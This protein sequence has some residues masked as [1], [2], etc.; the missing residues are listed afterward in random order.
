M[1]EKKYEVGGKSARILL[2]ALSLLTLVDFADRSVLTISLQAIKQAFDLTD[3]QAGMLP[4]LLQLGIALL[5]LPVSIFGDRWARRKAV[6]IMTTIWSIFTV[7]TGLAT[8]FW[9]M[10]VAR[11]MVGAGEAG[12]MPIGQTWMSV[13]FRKDVRSLMFSIF[14]MFM[15]IGTAI[16]TILGGIILTAT[17]NWR[18]AFFVFG[19]PG[20]LVA[21]WILFMRDYTVVKSGEGV[22]TKEYFKSWSKILRI[23]SWWLVT[24]TWLF[25]FFYNFA[26]LA[27]IPTLAIR[28]YNLTAAAAGTGLGL[29]ALVY[30]LGPIGGWLADR[31][32]RKSTNGRPYLSTIFVFL[33]VVTQT[34]AVLNVSLPF[35]TW[36]IIYAIS[37]IFFGLAA[38]V[39]M[40]L[41]Q[42]ITPPELRSTAL[43]M[44]NFI[45]QIGGGM[46]G[47]VAVGVVSDTLGGGVHGVQMGLLL[48]TAFA[49]VGVVLLMAM[50]KYYP[51]ME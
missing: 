26:I 22:L 12:Y 31:W 24:L 41:P 33:S 50:F 42:D 15:P 35:N 43:G 28:A 25:I 8:Q 13:S 38:P 18:I 48:A 21:I 45:A 34:I 30:V 16:G 7:V 37:Q 40:A 1:Q 17:G 23:K 44:S 9:H 4:S 20:L 14:Y 39:Y 46:W 2:I 5:I 49:L 11:F 6:M 36:I 19:L 3:A 32:Q 27:W 51:R 29:V 47:S 10:V